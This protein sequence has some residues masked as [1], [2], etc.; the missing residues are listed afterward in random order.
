MVTKIVNNSANDV[1]YYVQNIGTLLHNAPMPPVK[2]VV[3]AGATAY[4]RAVTGDTDLEAFLSKRGCTLSQ[5]RRS[6]I[7]IVAGQSNAVGYDESP[8]DADDVKRIPFCYYDGLERH[9]SF[10]NAEQVPFVNANCD[11]YQ[12]ML[13]TASSGTATKGIQYELAKNLIGHI[14]DDYE[15]EIYGWAYGGSGVA[16]GTEGSVSSTNTPTGSTKWGED[17]ALT[18]ATGRRLNVI[19]SRIATESKLAA[20]V[21]CQGEQDGMMNCSVSAYESAF[22]SMINKIEDLVINGNGNDAQTGQNPNFGSKVL[23]PKFLINA[24]AIYKDT[25]AENNSAWLNCKGGAYVCSFSDDKSFDIQS[26]LTLDQVN[27]IQSSADDDSGDRNGLIIFGKGA[28]GSLTYRLKSGT[29]SSQMPVY[30][31]IYNNLNGQYIGT[32]ICNWSSNGAISTPAISYKEAN[33]EIEARHPLWVVYPG[34]QK[35]WNTQG[36]FKQIIQWQKDNFTNF[37][38]VDVNAPTNNANATGTKAKS[39][40]GWKGYGFTSSTLDSHY[41]QGAFKKIGKDV[42][43]TIVKNIFAKATI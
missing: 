12:Q 9:G 16:S 2:K 8:W 30:C 28:D 38:D 37:V 33:V 5:V 42:A 26:N 27:V 15:L 14:P 36:T 6:Y 18:L 7:V 34:P 25:S 31:R 17:G 43:D 39:W 10:T 22:K 13:F 3:K 23:N 40:K 21:W 4:D 1:E 24:D 29:T 32:V 35:Y 41:G 19:L 20:I 11:R